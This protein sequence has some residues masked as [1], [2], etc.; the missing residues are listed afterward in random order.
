MNPPILKK[1]FIG[2]ASFGILEINVKE[3]L[4][5]Y[6][7][8][9]MLADLAMYQTK[10]VKKLYHF[11]SFDDALNIIA[12]GDLDKRINDITSSLKR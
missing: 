5:S 3:P 1:E 8:E 7:V 12:I 10:K 9:S 4:L 11:I 6:E 2:G